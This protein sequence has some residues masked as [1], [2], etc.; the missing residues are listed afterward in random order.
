MYHRTRQKDD[1]NV[2]SFRKKKN[3]LISYVSSLLVDGIF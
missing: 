2:L 3:S 1:L